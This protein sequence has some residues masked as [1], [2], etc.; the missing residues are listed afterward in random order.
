MPYGDPDPNDPN[1]LVGVELPADRQSI[2]EMARAFAEEFAALG[3]SEAELL[4]IFCS[5]Y[6]GGAHLAYRTLGEEAIRSII[7]ESVSVF[8]RVRVR[9]RDREEL[10]PISL[11]D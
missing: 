2:E 10:I 1:V 8:G 5:S 7:Q 3:H 9:V 11:G 6:F 4:R